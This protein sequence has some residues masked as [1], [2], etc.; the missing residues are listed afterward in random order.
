MTEMM[1]YGIAVPVLPA[2]ALDYGASSASLG[3]L[4][5]I[6]AATMIALMPLVGL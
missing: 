6:Y 2:L 3:F 1:L 5:G 4:F